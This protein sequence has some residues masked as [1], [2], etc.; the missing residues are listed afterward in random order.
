MSK[1]EVKSS[2]NRER[3]DLQAALDILMR[4]SRATN[5]QIS[6]SYLLKRL[7]QVA[8]VLQQEDAAIAAGALV[9][10]R[11]RRRELVRL[12]GRLLQAGRK[13]R[14][15]ARPL[16]IG[17]DA[18]HDL[19]MVDPTIAVEDL[20]SPSDC[21]AAAARLGRALDQLES[22]PDKPLYGFDLGGRDAD[23]AARHAVAGLWD[24]FQEAGGRPSATES[25]DFHALVAAVA[26]AAGRAEATLRRQILAV[27]RV[28][29]RDPEPPIRPRGARHRS[30]R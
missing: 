5:K 22:D 1:T 4:I 10:R 19:R 9:A 16:R 8:D 11:E 7:H 26:S 20:C 23:H 15:P 29:D 28:I 18:L 24:L 3:A 25:G 27:A 13:G 14:L 2:I 6:H 17:E 30:S 12:H 21:A